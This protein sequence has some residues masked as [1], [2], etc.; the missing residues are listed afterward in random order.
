[1]PRNHSAKNTDALDVLRDAIR[2]KT[3]GRLT[4]LALASRDGR[5]SVSA[6]STSYYGI[7]LALVVI[8]EFSTTFPHLA[9]SAMAFSIGGRRIVLGDIRNKPAEEPV[10]RNRKA[11]S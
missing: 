4:E 2:Q 7:Q 1:M 9:P 6:S 11:I 5:I 3:Q 8:K 10:P